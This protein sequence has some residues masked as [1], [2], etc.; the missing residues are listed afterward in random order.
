MSNAAPVRF[1]LIGYGAWGS[2]HAKA[3]AETDGAELR[4]IAVPSEE[5]QQRA[6]ADFPDAVV[7]VDYR[8]ILGRDDIDAV[9]IVLPTHLHHEASVNAFESGKHVL[10]EKPMAASMFE[11]QEI[12]HA[13]ADAG[14]VF[15]IGHEFRL[16]S[17]WGEVR[18]IIERGEIGDPQYVLVELSRKP[19]RLGS[20]GWRYDIERVGN[21]ILEEPIHF[22]DLARWY[23]SGAGAPT[24]IYASANSR[25]EDHPELQDNF[26][27]IMRWENG[28]Y[29]VISQTLAAFEHH[30]TVKVSGTKG[31]LWAGWSG[32][33]D[34]TD[35]PSFFLRL[36]R[37]HGGDAETI[38]LDVPS[39][40]LFE[41]RWEIERMVQ[42]IRGEASPAATGE[43]GL[44]SVGMCLAAQQSV[45]SG[46]PVDLQTFMAPYTS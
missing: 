45:D 33:L 15:S 44:W 25:H 35:K 41:L 38:D 46:K 26:S 27:A 28:P 14:T 5:S 36:M 32:A 20:G 4:A 37:E 24:S 2:H 42:S 3:I 17:Q 34:R 13:A 29:A 1:G 31:A 10:L 30:Q 21:W 22:F 40:E 16:S 43:D 18:N 11:C 39:G 19:Y 9:D 12:L 23:L 8:E 6:R 7:A